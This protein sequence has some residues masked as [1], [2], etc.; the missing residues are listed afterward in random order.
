MRTIS[1]EGLSPILL[2]FY[3]S[4]RKQSRNREDRGRNE[5]GIHRISKIYRLKQ[6][7]VDNGKVPKRQNENLTRRTK[8]M[9]LYAYL[10]ATW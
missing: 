1:K 4:L 6:N 5:N 3:V 10:I 2:H 9:T 7:H 8:F